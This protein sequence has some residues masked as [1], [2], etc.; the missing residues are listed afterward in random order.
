MK[1]RIISLGLAI[2]WG[3]IYGVAMKVVDL[4]QDHGLQISATKENLCY[5]MAV[6]DIYMLCTMVPGGR[7]FLAYQIVYHGLIKGKA[8]TL[9]HVI[10]G[11]CSV[12]HVCLP[13]VGGALVSRLVIH[14]YYYLCLSG[15]VYLE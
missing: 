11:R 2:V 3:M 5:L 13:C 4:T 8:D 10:M 15:V 12:Q 9:K 14:C 6:L 1:T 7:W